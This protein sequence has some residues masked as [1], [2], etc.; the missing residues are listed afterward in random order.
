MR[1]AASLMLPAISL[2]FGLYGR[3]LDGGKRLDCRSILLGQLRERL[4]YLVE[5]CHVLLLHFREGAPMLARS[6]TMATPSDTRTCGLAMCRV[7]GLDEVRHHPE[8][9]PAGLCRL[10]EVDD[11]RDFPREP[12]DEPEGHHVLLREVVTMTP[13]LSWM[14][15]WSRTL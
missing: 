5:V 11:V 8:R 7:P 15:A 1:A 9:V 6:A 10:V 2:D 4:V 14:T 12:P 3:V 13:A